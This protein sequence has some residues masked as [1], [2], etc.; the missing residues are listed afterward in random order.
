MEVRIQWIQRDLPVVELQGD[1]NVQ[2]A[3]SVRKVL[4]RLSKKHIRL[5]IVDLSGLCSVDSA[6]IA[7]LVEAL[8][9]VSGRG[10]QFKLAAVREK[11]GQ[12]L[13]LTRL[14]QL[15]V[16]CDSVATALASAGVQLETRLAGE[17]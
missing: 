17:D 11:V 15:F 7:V 12:M 5:L 14:D 16:V 2:T 13:R 8:K 6:G 4:L 10:G 9:A 3:L 1:F